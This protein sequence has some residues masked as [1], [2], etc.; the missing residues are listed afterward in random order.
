MPAL[1]LT[2]EDPPRLGRYRLL[3]RL[4]EGGQ[5]IVYLGEGAPGEHVA[6]KVIKTATDPA[7]RDRLAREMAAAQQVADWCTAK[8]LDSSVDG[9]LPYI[10]SEFV[11][12]PSLRDRV[13]E[14]GPLHGGELKRLMA[15]TLTA[16][17]AIHGAGMIHRDLKPGNVL[18]GPDGPRVVDFGIARP[19]DQRTMSGQLTGTPA[20]LSPEQL[21]QE[22]AT[23]ASDVFAWAGTMVYA[24]TGHP[25]FR[26]GAIAPLFQ[27]ILNDPPDLSGVPA[28][29][30]EMLAE[31]LDKD[32]GARPTARDLHERLV[33]GPPPLPPWAGRRPEDPTVDRRTRP[34]APVR[35]AE[36]REE[37]G[38]SAV[39]SVTTDPA[40]E[41]A[42][43]SRR[44]WIVPVAVA[45]AA[46]AGLVGW[47]AG[48]GED[49][50]SIPAEYAGVWSGPAFESTGIGGRTSTVTIELA[51]G[52]RTARL[53]SAICP[54]GLRL[55][56]A[57]GDR[58]TFTF[59]SGQCAPGQVIVEL[60]DGG[61]G[62]RLRGAGAITGE[63]GEPL[64]RAG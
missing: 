11:D 7:A 35:A 24:A 45:V 34:P 48:R 42:G 8:V 38:E 29:L 12:G 64:R 63:S 25:P 30:R 4:G 22:S 27:A 31:C 51:A 14:R 6:V 33:G 17:L 36:T 18:L 37:T 49:A 61:L 62:Y 43:A 16:L 10:V 23:R 55:A 28:E 54:G 59:E 5:G 58:L 60:R 19:V 15:N 13:R 44:A 56:E 20:Y 50:P 57:G 3:G 2:P 52:Q 26:H 41:P 40:P 39:S 47:L 46:G 21:R 32:P 53:E 1:P 9:P